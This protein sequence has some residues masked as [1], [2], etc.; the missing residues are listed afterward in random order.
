MT[1]VPAVSKRGDGTTDIFYIGDYNEMYGLWDKNAPFRFHRLRGSERG[2][3]YRLAAVIL[4]ENSVE[5]FAVGVTDGRLYRVHLEASGEGNPSFRK[6]SSDRWYG[7]P[8]ALSPIKVRA[9]VF[10]IGANSQLQYIT[11][12]N[13]SEDPLFFPE[14]PGYQKSLHLS[15]EVT[16]NLGIGT[17]RNITDGQ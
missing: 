16:R 1:N 2:F 9:D 12:A 15:K 13:F 4:D 3:L 5:V 8:K 11:F 6:K 14:T 10:G 7:T 17:R